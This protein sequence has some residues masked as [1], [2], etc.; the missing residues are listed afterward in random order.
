MI[1]TGSGQSVAYDSETGE[2]F[3]FQSVAKTLMLN[4]VET[5]VLNDLITG[6]PGYPDNAIRCV[7]A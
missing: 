1:Y 6:T 2:I 5:S 3:E 7:P 4:G